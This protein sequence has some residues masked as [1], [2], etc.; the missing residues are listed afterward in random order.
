MYLDDFGTNLTGAGAEL[1]A[2]AVSIL[3]V[4]HTDVGTASRGNH[5]H[6]HTYIHTHKHTI[7]NLTWGGLTT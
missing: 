3:P 5:L 1:L 6:P 4:D 2:G 7:V